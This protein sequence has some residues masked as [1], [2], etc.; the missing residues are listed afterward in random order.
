MLE[1]TFYQVLHSLA[2]ANSTKA[3]Q[4]VFLTE[5]ED[6]RQ[7]IIDSLNNVCHPEDEAVPQEWQQEQE[8]IY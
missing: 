6:W 1:G 4:T 5:L 2:I 3:F 8:A 7:A